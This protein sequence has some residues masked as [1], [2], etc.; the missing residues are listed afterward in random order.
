MSGEELVT[1]LPAPAES[2]RVLR[3][4]NTGPCSFLGYEFK[5]AE[6]PVGIQD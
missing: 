1:V 6:S 5:G 2:Y 3:I 4:P